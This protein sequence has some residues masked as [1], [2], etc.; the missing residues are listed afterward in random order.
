M[1]SPLSLF[2]LVTST[3]LLSVYSLV[4]API[5]TDSIQAKEGTL[6]S[7]SIHRVA[8]APGTTNSLSFEGK[9]NILVSDQGTQVETVLDGVRRNVIIIDKD[10]FVLETRSDGFQAGEIWTVTN[11][12]AVGKNII[13]T[14]YILERMAEEHPL[15]AGT[16]STYAKS[17]FHM[18]S[19]LQADV[20]NGVSCDRNLRED[21]VEDR[22]YVTRRFVEGA[23][24]PVVAYGGRGFL[25]L[26]LNSKVGKI[27]PGETI[28]VMEYWPKIKPA[29]A[30]DVYPFRD[31]QLLV[32]DVQMVTNVN[33][34]PKVLYAGARLEDYRFQYANGK[35]MNVPLNPVLWVSRQSKGW[36]EYLK[37]AETVL[38]TRPAYL[39]TK[40]QGHSKK[41]LV[42]L[43][44]MSVFTAGVIIVAICLR[45]RKMVNK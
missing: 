39:D 14:Q 34:L 22:W 19:G 21:T 15:G 4:S 45:S 16:S 17:W 24:M 20:D 7:G 35:P 9:W 42:I 23:S 5:G 28:S 31:T 33:L 12:V 44:F 37:I 26:S 41:R 6:I 2:F 43:T 30:E 36:S 38:I 18:S 32:A 11:G 8:Y 1:T 29:S 25:A 40:S 27:T 3:F 13:L 10:E